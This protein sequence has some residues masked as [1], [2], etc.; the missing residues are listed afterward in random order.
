MKLLPAISRGV[1][2]M[3]LTTP[4]SALAPHTAEAG[5]RMTSIWR[6]SFG[7]TGRKSQATKPKKSRYRL[8]P[9]M[10]ASCEVA[11][12]EVAPR[13]LMLKSRAEVCVM[14]MPGTERSSSA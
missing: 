8:R 1:L 12:V 4:E 14:F 3:K 6:T 10:S 13:M 11:S 2:V 7:L 9:S 5:P